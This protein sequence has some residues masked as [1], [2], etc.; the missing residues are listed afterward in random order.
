MLWDGKFSK[1]LYPAVKPTGYNHDWTSNAILA[2]TSSPFLSL[3]SY[4]NNLLAWSISPSFC[5]NNPSSNI[6]IKD[7][8]CLVFQLFY[9]SEY[10]KCWAIASGHDFFSVQRRKL[11]SRIYH[12]TYLSFR[13][14]SANL[15]Y[16]CWDLVPNLLLYY[17]SSHKLTL[18]TDLAEVFL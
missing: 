4:S 17:I 10:I 5:V 3:I 9:M 1:Y 11:W 6:F 8:P 16:S 13:Q 2:W 7:F 15:K 18:L 12:E 14:K